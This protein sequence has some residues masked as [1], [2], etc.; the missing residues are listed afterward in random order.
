MAW[1]TRWVTPE[2]IQFGAKAGQFFETWVVSEIIKYFLNAG[3]SL[4]DMTYY[5]DADQREI[6]LVLEVE[7]TVYPIETKPLPALKC[8]GLYCD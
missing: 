1:L 3:K 5:R 4:R 7:R 6:D 2:T 8:R